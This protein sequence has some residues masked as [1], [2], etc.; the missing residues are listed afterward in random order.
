MTKKELK[1]E[2]LNAS[3]E[4]DLQGY[5]KADVIFKTDFDK[6]I[7]KLAEKLPIM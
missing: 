3:V 4:I 5:G 1:Q 6:L 2:L 7:D